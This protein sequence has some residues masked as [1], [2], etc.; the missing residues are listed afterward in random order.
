MTFE[1][2]V[3]HKVVNVFIL[4]PELAALDKYALLSKGIM[5]LSYEL[6]VLNGKTFHL[7]V[8][9]SGELFEIV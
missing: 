8:E 3:R 5:I 1:G 7:R 6:A 2:N 9:F 4:R